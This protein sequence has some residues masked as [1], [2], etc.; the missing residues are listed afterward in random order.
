MSDQRG[1]K[2]PRTE[3]GASAP[4]QQD[5][6]VP[7]RWSVGE[8]YDEGSRAAPRASAPLDVGGIDID[9]LALALAEKLKPQEA[10]LP[11]L[12]ELAGAWFDSIEGKRVVP[13]REAVLMG[14]LRPLFLDDERT[15]TVDSINR[16]LEGM[17]A[18][19]YAAATVNK[20][21]GAGRL[22]V[23]HAQSCKRW[24]GPN[25]FGLV[26]RKREAQRQYELLSLAEL[27]QVQRKLSPDKRR[28][29]RVQLH[30]GLRTGEMLALQREDVDF[31]AGTVRVHRSHGRDQTKTGR[32]RLVPLH[33]AC[34]G[35]LLEATQLTTGALL[36]PSSLGTLQRMD[37]K[38]TRALRTAMGRAGVG[39][40]SVVYKC[41][42]R[43]CDAQPETHDPAASIEALDCVSCGFRLW[44]VPEVRP[45]RWY[46][47][48]HMCATFHREAGADPI[49]IS[50]ALGHAL[51]NTT[52]AH[53]THPS[54][55]WMRGQLTRW[56]LP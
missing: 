48:R 14:H 34:A 9:Q 17:L 42:R 45:V 30:L 50:L 18:A 2:P 33:P 54:L 39:I 11:M 56:K 7:P 4:S 22:I 40:T 53:Y 24:S 44:P 55:E 32:E 38:L 20:V 27:A 49:A 6:E 52:D 3:R 10:E 15:L 31:N 43:G 37:T 8:Q 46:D 19:G 36:F 35:D 51:R 25:P 12:G 13:A 1:R 21:R 29:F 47:L 26:R 23:D 28:M 41:R 5:G 16:L